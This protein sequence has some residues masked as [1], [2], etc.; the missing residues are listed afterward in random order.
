MPT[1]DPVLT[2]AGYLLLKAGHFVGEEFDATLGSLGLNRREFLML[3]YVSASEG[4]SQQELS[5][6]LGIDPTI[7]VG[8]VDSLEDRGLMTRTRDAADRRRNVLGLTDAGHDLHAKA[9][10]TAAVAEDQFLAPL[11]DAER[12]HAPRPCSTR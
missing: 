8:L 2:S 1:S 4:L 7:V 10:E 3:S 12:R 5:A 6:R 9:V 11:S